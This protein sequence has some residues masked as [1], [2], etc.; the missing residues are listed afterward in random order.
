VATRSRWRHLAWFY[1]AATTLV[2]LAS[3]NHFL[4]DAVGGLAVAGVGVLAAS[5][6]SWWRAM[7]TGRG[8]WLAAATGYTALASCVGASARAPPPRRAPGGRARGVHGGA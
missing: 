2:V 5:Q 1:P 6:P 7:I 8:W 3:A 4:L